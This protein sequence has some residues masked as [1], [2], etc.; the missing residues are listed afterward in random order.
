MVLQRQRCGRVGRRRDS[1]S[2]SEHRPPGRYA[3]QSSRSGCVRSAGLRPASIAER[4]S[5]PLTPPICTADA[6]PNA[7]STVP[8][9]TTWN[10]GF[11][12]HP[13][14]ASA[15]ER[16][17]A[18]FLH[19]ATGTGT[20]T[21]GRHPGCGAPRNRTPQSSRQEEPEGNVPPVDG[22][23]AWN[24]GFSRHP[25][26]ESAAARRTALFLHSATG[27]GRRPRVGTRGAEHRRTVR[28]NHPDR[29]NRRA[30]S[31]QLT[32]I[33]AWNAGFSRHPLR[34]SAAERRTAPFLHSA[35][36]TGTPTSGRHPG[37]GAPRNRTPQSSRQ[38]E[39]EGNV[40]PVDGI[41][42]WNAGFS[43]QPLRESAA[44]RRT[45]PF[46]HSATGTGTPTSGR[47]PGCG[48]PRNRT[49][50]S[51]PQEEPEGNVPPVDGITA[52][53]AGFSRHPLRESAAEPDHSIR[54]H[55]DGV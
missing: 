14:R 3:L 46:L 11:S 44:E 29:K 32:G 34:E 18:P 45:A 24:A 13:L 8:A 9:V 41:T 53:N 38:E 52:W 48:A 36:G 23:T 17:T 55:S 20:P 4:R 1:R 16:R 25:L 37:C 5:K 40:P 50:Q 54:P 26:R 47:H 12:R 39:P 2:R 42:A 31:L 21:S 33:T 43:R 28:P 22:I 35:T 27:T 49:P 7:T 51:S 19:S 15:A 30:T 6:V 10:A